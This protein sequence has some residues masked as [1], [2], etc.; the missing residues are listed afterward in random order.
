M[1][2]SMHISGKGNIYAAADQIA[3][4]D[5]SERDRGKGAQRVSHA[6]DGEHRR[7]YTSCSSGP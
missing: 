1:A 3:S 4:V 7:S 5:L 2:L 6:D